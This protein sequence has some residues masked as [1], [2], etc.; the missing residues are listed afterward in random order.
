VSVLTILAELSV[1]E[2]INR[3]RQDKNRSIASSYPVNPVHPCL[4]LS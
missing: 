4:N 1:E 3:D 2:E